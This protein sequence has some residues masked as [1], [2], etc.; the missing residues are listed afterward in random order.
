M[1]G[2]LIAC[3]VRPGDTVAIFCGNGIFSAETI[4]GA[5]AGGAIAVPLNWRWSRPGLQDGLSDYEARIV[6]AD[7]EFA[8]AIEELN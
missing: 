3:G 7:K 5:M 8:P 6:I 1:A 4:L 2:G